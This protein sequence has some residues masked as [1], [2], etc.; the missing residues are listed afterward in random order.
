MLF[1]TLQQQTLHA[2]LG[3]VGRKR[4][5]VNVS[6]YSIKIANKPFDKFKYY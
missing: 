3:R 2:N 6:C 5:F 1:L 4:N